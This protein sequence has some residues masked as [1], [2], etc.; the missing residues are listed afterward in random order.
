MLRG[1]CEESY[2]SHRFLQ[3]PWPQGAS[4]PLSLWLLFWVIMCH[5]WPTVHSCMTTTM[6]MMFLHFPHALFCI[7][8]ITMGCR[9]PTV[10]VHGHHHDHNLYLRT[11]CL[12]AAHLHIF[13]R[14]GCLLASL[15]HALPMYIS[16]CHPLAMA[17]HFYYNK[18]LCLPIGEA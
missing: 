14:T 7:T 5:W 9:R 15:P 8:C 16:K 2:A 10:H 13:L 6:A 12:P 11:S 4:C 3:Y 1:F 17:T 18:N